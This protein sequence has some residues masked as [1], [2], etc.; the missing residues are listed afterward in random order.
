MVTTVGCHQPL[1]EAFDVRGGMG[2]KRLALQLR[3]RIEP[4]LDVRS[5]SNPLKGCSL[6]VLSA[7][8]QDSLRTIIARLYPLPLSPDPCYA[9][10][11]GLSHP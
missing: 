1:E 2:T 8:A 7:V 11:D 3:V 10:L 9:A 5:R 4:P 6:R